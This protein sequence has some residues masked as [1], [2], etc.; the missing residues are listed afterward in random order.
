MNVKQ[1]FDQHAANWDEKPERVELASQICECLLGQVELNAEMAVLD[2]G[3]GTGLV[4]L[5][6]AG[7]VKTLVGL[8]SSPA[9][10]EVFMEKA[11]QQGLSN[12]QTLEVDPGHDENLSGP[13][14]LV[15]SSMVFHHIEDTEA[16]LE[17]LHGVLKPSGWLVLVDLDP[18]GGLFHSTPEGIFHEGFDR[19]ELGRMWEQAEFCEVSTTL[20]ATCV[21]RVAA[22]NQEHEFSIFLMK[23]RKSPPRRA[24]D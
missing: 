22:T 10:L 17:R 16:L 11:R 1:H 18:D 13:Y 5:P 7:Q 9:M 4:S 20:A 6:W 21:K 14:D 15:L 8:D 12:V 19:E 23:G 3:C 2:F 24:G